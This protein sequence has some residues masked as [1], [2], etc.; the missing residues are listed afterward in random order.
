MF[1]LSLA[2][3]AAQAANANKTFYLSAPGDS[4]AKVW[5]KSLVF[6]PDSDGALAI[7]GTNYITVTAKNGS[8]SLGSFTTFTG[9]TALVAGTAVAFSLSG[10][11]EFTALTGILTIDS[12]K[13]GTGGVLKGIF[14]ATFEQ[15]RNG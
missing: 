1:L 8:S 13:T 3:I 11:I 14:V 7:D 9:G 6:I 10:P 12:V 4:S 5:L 15:I 2:L